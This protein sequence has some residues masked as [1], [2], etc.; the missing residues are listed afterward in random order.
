MLYLSA[1]EAIGVLWSTG[2]LPLT[3]S[4]LVVTCLSGF[5]ERKC[6]MN[7]LLAAKPG[8]AGVGVASGQFQKWSGCVGNNDTQKACDEN[9]AAR[10]PDD[11]DIY[12]FNAISLYTLK[13][14]S[15]A[16]LAEGVWSAI[17]GTAFQ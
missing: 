7:E 8:R 1:G 3:T 2:E 14:T 4:T 11:C 12:A 5:K 16:S 9:S 15:T 6:I 10:V 17:H 13:R